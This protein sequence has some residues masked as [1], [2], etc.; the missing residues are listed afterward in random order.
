MKGAM[1]Q[2]QPAPPSSESVDSQEA[3]LPLQS[4]TAAAGSSGGGDAESHIN[5]EGVSNA[6]TPRRV[7]AGTPLFSPSE[8]WTLAALQKLQKQVLDLQEQL[9][10]SEAKVGMWEECMQQLMHS[11]LLSPDMNDMYKS[12]CVELLQEVPSLVSALCDATLLTP[13]C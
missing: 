11:L 1:Q 6:S 12:V 5:G 4:G 8:P 10:A 7:D 3:K 2:A 9:R 13:S